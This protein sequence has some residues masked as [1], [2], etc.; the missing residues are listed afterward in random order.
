MVESQNVIQASI[1]KGSYPQRQW[2]KRPD[3]DWNQAKDCEN[4]NE[5]IKELIGN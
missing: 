2:K 1:C 4:R 3:P 5:I